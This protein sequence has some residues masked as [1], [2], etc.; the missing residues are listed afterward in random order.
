ME[1]SDERARYDRSHWSREED[2]KK[3]I[4]Q[5]LRLSEKVFNRTTFKLFGSMIGKVSG[6]KIL[7]Y[8]GGA[9]I[10]A[11][12][13]A[14]T[15]ADVVL[16]DAEAN[17][18]RAACFYARREG[19]EGKLRAIHSDSFPF[20]LKKERFDIV[21]AKD[22][23]E[24]IQDDEGFLSDLAECQAKGGTLMLSTQ[25]SRS[26]NYL[27][28]GSY[29]TYWCNNT[30]WCGWDQ[31]HLRFYTPASLGKKLKKAKYRVDRWASVYLI[32]YNILSWLFLLKVDIELPV[33]HF[34]DLTLGTVFPFNRLGWNVVV[35]AVRE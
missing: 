30:N 32:P 13:Y 5:Y 17:A 2:E 9:G 22:I 19:V 3:A 24:H 29:Q 10:M 23:I 1:I 12:P 8:G 4:D 28:E 14:K 7:D 16:V 21:I 27:L 34:C 25:N 11:I 33:L 31:T 26:L 20:V 18:L 35:R 15:G 6:K